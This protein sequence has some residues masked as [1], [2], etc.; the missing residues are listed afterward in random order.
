ML[1]WLPENQQT[2]RGRAWR[3]RFCSD[4]AQIWN[5]A[6]QRVYLWVHRTKFRFS[7]S[8]Y[9]LGPLIFGQTEKI[10]KIEQNR[11]KIR[12]RDRNELPRVPV[13]W[14]PKTLKKIFLKKMPY[15]PNI[16]ENERNRATELDKRSKMVKIVKNQ[17]TFGQNQQTL[18]KSNCRTTLTPTVVQQEIEELIRKRVDFFRQTKNVRKISPAGK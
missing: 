14:S 15:I 17:Q 2:L 11:A 6:S 4:R 8:R 16:P 3:L 9:P 13:T 5:L 7:D 1:P 10:T 18:P 12:S